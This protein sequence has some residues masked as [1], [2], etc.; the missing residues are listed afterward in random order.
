MVDNQ[1]KSELS[2]LGATGVK[3]EAAYLLI[4]NKN[5]FDIDK[6]DGKTI[7]Q[8]QDGFDI[9]EVV[10]EWS[11]TT[12]GKELLPPVINSGGGASG[13][14][15]GRGKQ[16]DLATEIKKAEAEGRTRDAI[17]LK[18]MASKQN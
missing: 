8:N 13:S 6:V 4:K 17:R 3:L 5:N 2:S 16:V 10:K 9:S 7:V 1:I 14:G 18:R 12:E 15:L 11:D